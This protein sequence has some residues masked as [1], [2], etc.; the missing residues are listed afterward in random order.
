MVNDDPSLPAST[1][2]IS[3]SQSAIVNTEQKY[4][5]NSD[6]QTTFKTTDQNQDGTYVITYTQT[7]SISGSEQSA[8]VKIRAIWDECTPNMQVTG[9]LQPTYDYHIAS[10]RM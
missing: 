7:E 8:T 6:A 4:S 3:V 1:T 5:F 2:H 9:T 10:N